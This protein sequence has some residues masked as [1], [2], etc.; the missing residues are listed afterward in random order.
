MT[1]RG[2]VT[3]RALWHAARG[4]GSAEWQ[5]TTSSGCCRRRGRTLAHRIY[6]RRLAARPH[7]P[8]E[9][10]TRSHRPASLS[11]PRLSSPPH[12][13]PFKSPQTH[14][15]RFLC[16]P[17]P[18]HPRRP[19]ASHPSYSSASPTSASA[20]Q[21]HRAG[22]SQRSRSLEPVRRTFSGVQCAV[23][24]KARRP[25][26]FS[27]PRSSLARSCQRLRRFAASFHLRRQS[28]NS[29]RITCHPA[30]SIRLSA[31]QPH[32]FC[33]CIGAAQVRR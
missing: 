24:P 25:S 8:F 10:A 6:W 12:P 3:R 2:Q 9:P 16:L 15:P 29:A 27:P 14:G 21:C 5:R 22:S 1:S 33:K 18:L 31:S 19:I 20:G 30:P 4:I 7:R 13:R 17:W 11:T 26:S 28:G 32:E 23:T